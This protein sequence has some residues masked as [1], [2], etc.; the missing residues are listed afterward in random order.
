M[1]TSKENAFK[2][3]FI[4]LNCHLPVST[5]GRDRIFLKHNGKR[6]YP[7]GGGKF[8]EFKKGDAHKFKDLSLFIPK[9]EKTVMVELWK[10]HWLYRNTLVGRFFFITNISETGFSAT[11]LIRN[12]EYHLSNYLLHWEKRN[13]EPVIKEN[14]SV[15]N[16]KVQVLK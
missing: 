5:R 7:S 13:P 6:L 16:E 4:S 11:Q 15:N 8:L 14:S 10:Y 9:E 3:N 2:I 1:D 12:S